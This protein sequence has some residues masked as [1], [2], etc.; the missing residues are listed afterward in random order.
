M[1]LVKIFLTQFIYAVY[2]IYVIYFG[3]AMKRL[4]LGCMLFLISFLPSRT[5]AQYMVHEENFLKSALNVAGLP[6][7][8]PFSSYEN[9]DRGLELKSAFLMPVI[10]AMKKYGFSIEIHKPRETGNSPE[11]NIHVQNIILNTNDGLFNLFIGSY[12]DTKLF[13]GMSLIYPAV[14]SNPVHIITLP[15]TQQKIKKA[16]DLKSL[17]GIVC[18]SEYFSD[19]VLRKIKSLNITYVDTP[20]EAYEKLFVGDADYLL[21][22]M[23]YNRMMASKYGIEHYLAYSKK[24]LFKIPIFIAM[25]KQTPLFSEYMKVFQTEFSKPEFGDEVK[26]EILR[27]VEEEVRKNQGIVPP[28]FA[29][30]VVENK[31][32][33]IEKKAETSTEDL[34]GKIIKKEIKQKTIDEVLDGI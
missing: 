32:D 13:K 33:D 17:R 11:D 27:I 21:G 8:P 6:D 29:K 14:I 1:Q 7:F 26:K 20:L 25:S 22:S 28:A 12:A 5:D 19:F 15:D 4:F 3:G 9:T 16:S 31:V 18:K 23:Y 2:C 10:N 34:G 30:K 24:P